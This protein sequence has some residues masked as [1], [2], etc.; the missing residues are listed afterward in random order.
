[1][2]SCSF[3]P[4][5]AYIS[6]PGL[7]LPSTM[8]YWLADTALGRPAVLDNPPEAVSALVNCAVL[9]LA[10]LSHAFELT[11][12]A[13]ASG[14]DGVLAGNDRREIVVLVAGVVVVVGFLVWGS[15]NAGAIEAPRWLSWLFD[16]C[17]VDE[18]ASEGGCQQA[19][20]RQ[21]WEARRRRQ[22][23]IVITTTGRPNN[24]RDARV[25]TGAYL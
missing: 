11:L 21:A 20:T 1:M 16:A 6:N 12:A 10:V 7:P 13:M 9:A 17:V 18:I 15:G 8:R 3:Y 2:Y 22:P 25:Q 19:A 23:T 14:D 4:V 5:L 24:R